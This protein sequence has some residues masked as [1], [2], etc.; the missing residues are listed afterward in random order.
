PHKDQTYMLSAL[1][2]ATLARLRFPLGGLT[3]P[4]VRE[5][6]REAGLPVAEK[7][8]SQDLCFLAGT[9]R[10]R[11]LTRHAR[12]RDEPG[13]VV[14]ARGRV[15]GRHRGHRGFTVGQRK[16]LGLA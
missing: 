4:E 1:R 13:E 5:V 8:E 14:D 11:F 10:E 2:P 7:R 9:T 3:K 16:G 6:A 15:L 12:V